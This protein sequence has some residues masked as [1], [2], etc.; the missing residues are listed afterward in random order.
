MDGYDEEVVI[1]EPPYWMFIFE[2]P[3]N[4]WWLKISNANDLVNYHNKTVGMYQNVISDYMHNKEK[5]DETGRY[6]VFDNI[7]TYAIVMYAEKHHLTMLD[8]CIRFR[9]Y[10]AEKQLHAIHEHGFICI[11]KVGGWHSG[12][13]V[14]FSQFVHRKTFTWPDFSESDIRIT[15]FNGGKHWYVHIGDMELHEDGNIK[16]NT[17]EE[18][19]QAAMR[20]VGKE[21]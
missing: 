2:E 14:E 10:L 20:Y 3:D 11:N 8:A 4:G 1:T 18:A 12:E 16:W 9:M 21:K 6:D 19:R 7:R 5:Y 17:K 15:Q 13:M